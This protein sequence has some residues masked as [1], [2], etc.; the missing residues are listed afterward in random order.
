MHVVRAFV[1][2]HGF[3]IEHVS[4]DVILIDDAVGAVHV[5]RHPR[6]VQRLAA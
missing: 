4:D 1:G 5:P 2:V 3:E 6:D